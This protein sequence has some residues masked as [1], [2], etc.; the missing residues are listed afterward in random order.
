[1]GMG[2]WMGIVMGWMGNDGGGYGERDGNGDVMGR[3]YGW[4]RALIGVWDGWEREGR[5]ER[6][7]ICMV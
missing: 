1:M 7:G 3:G 2:E 5:C 4:E 6:A